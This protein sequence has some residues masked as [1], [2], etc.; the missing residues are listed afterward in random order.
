MDC[1]TPDLT[2]ALDSLSKRYNRS[3]IDE[4]GK[5]HEKLEDILMLELGSLE[6]DKDLCEYE[7]WDSL[8]HL[9]LLA[10]FDKDLGVKLSVE[11][12]RNFKKVSDIFTK[13]NL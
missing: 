11:D 8:A 9:S 5:S 1:I 6:L 10:L 2:A 3:G 12:V 4:W 13:A 7:D